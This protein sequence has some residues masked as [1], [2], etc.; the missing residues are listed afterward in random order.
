MNENWIQNRV[1]Y[2]ETLDDLYKD[3]FTLIR[4]SKIPMDMRTSGQKAWITR[5]S[6]AEHEREIKKIYEEAVLAARKLSE[7]ERKTI[8]QSKDFEYDTVLIDLASDES[9]IVRWNLARNP[10]IPL[11]AMLLLSKDRCDDVLSCLILNPATPDS[12]I[13]KMARNK[14]LK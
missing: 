2:L 14:L 4:L 10:S 11:K 13:A 6:T 12:L 5:C 8:A 7:L 9:E 1:K 3:Q